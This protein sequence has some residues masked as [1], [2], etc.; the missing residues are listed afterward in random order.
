MSENIQP[1]AALRHISKSYGKKRI[2][3]DISLEVSA[4]TCVGILGK[5]DAASPRF[6]RFLPEHLPV[7]RALFFMAHEICLPTGSSGPL[8]SAMCP[9]G[10]R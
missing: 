8:W 9:R 5:M 10:R 3:D 6:C 7:R 4:G 1:A 2:L